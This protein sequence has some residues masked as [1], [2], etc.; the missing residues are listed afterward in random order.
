MLQ[1]YLFN[2]AVK[3]NVVVYLET[4][5]GK[6][7]IAVMLINHKLY[8]TNGKYPEEGKRTVFLAPTRPLV[9]QHL[10]TLTEFIPC[11]I[12]RLTGDHNVDYFTLEEWRNYFQNH[13]ILLCTPQVLVDALIKGFV[14]ISNFNLL[15][16]DEAH[17]CLKKNG[18]HSMHPYRK[19]MDL[20]KEQTKDVKPD[21]KPR[22]L[23][24]SAS[25]LNAL[26]ES[27]SIDK[28]V[29]EIQ[30]IY[31]ATVESYDIR[32]YLKSAKVFIL[33][34]D[35]SMFQ[36]RICAKRRCN[37]EEII[38]V[39]DLCQSL[40][41]EYSLAKSLR[42]AIEKV[43]R[44]C[45][46]E[47]GPWFAIEALCIYKKSCNDS[48]QKL[49][50][51]LFNFLEMKI[52]SSFQEVQLDSE[53]ISEKVSELLKM[54]Y[55]FRNN[56]NC[57]I[58]VNER[59]DANVLF[60]YLKFIS[61]TNPK[62]DFI[63]PGFIC[64]SLS[65]DFI[66]FDSNTNNFKELFEQNKLNILIA[67]AVLE[68]GID[69]P[70]C[71]LVIRYDFTPNFR[72]FVQSKGRARD[73]NSFYILM[74]DSI[75]EQLNWKKLLK[76]YYFIE[77]YLTR[78]S[79]TENKTS[80]TSKF[81][82]NET[83]TIEYEKFCTQYA[84]CSEKDSLQLLNHYLQ[85]LPIDSF[86]D[87]RPNFVEYQPNNDINSVNTTEYIYIFIFPINSSIPG[88]I[89]GN[90][91]PNKHD[92]KLNCAFNVCKYLYG[93][94]EIDEHLNIKTK[95]F[96]ISNHYKELNLQIVIENGKRKNF[97][98]FVSKK[99]EYCRKNSLFAE[100][101][102][103]FKI[104]QQWN[105]CVVDFSENAPNIPLLDNYNY[106]QSTKMGFIINQDQSLHRC[107]SFIYLNKMRIK[108]NIKHIVSFA[109]FDSEKIQAISFFSQHIRQHV[110][111]DGIDNF[112]T[113]TKKTEDAINFYYVP[114]KQTSLVNHEIDYDLIY[115]LQMWEQ[116][117]EH[118]SSKSKKVKIDLENRQN[119]LEQFE[120]KTIFSCIHRGFPKMY[121][122]KNVSDVLPSHTFE[123]NEKKDFAQITTYTDYYQNNYGYQLK[124]LDLPL[125]NSGNLKALVMNKYKFSLSFIIPKIEKEKTSNRLL[126]PIE[127]VL[128]YPMPMWS[129]MLWNSMPFVLYRLES[130]LIGNDVLNL[131]QKSNIRSFRDDINVET[132]ITANNYQNQLYNHE[133]NSDEFNMES[134]SETEDSTETNDQYKLTNIDQI[135]FQD[136]TIKTALTQNVL[137]EK[138]S[139]IISLNDS[140]NKWIE[141]NIKDE[142]T[143]TNEFGELLEKLRNHIFNSKLSY[144]DQRILFSQM[145]ESLKFGDTSLFIFTGDIEPHI[146]SIRFNTFDLNS[147]QYH[148]PNPWY[149]TKALTIN[150]SKDIWD[151]EQLETVGDSFLKMTTTLYLYFHY[152][153]YDE[154]K[155]SLLKTAM[156]CNENLFRSA[157]IKDLQMYMIGNKL[158][159]GNNWIVPFYPFDCKRQQPM[160]GPNRFKSIQIMNGDDIADCVEA[161]I[162][163]FIVYGSARG[164]LDFFQWIGL[165]CFDPI[166][167]QKNIDPVKYYEQEYEKNIETIQNEIGSS[168]M[169][170]LPEINIGKFVNEIYNSCFLKNVEEVINYKF[171]HKFYLGK[172]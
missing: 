118:L 85:R 140:D 74:V 165:K 29:Q 111:M 17:W 146:G 16:F 15:I 104:E 40:S 65:K 120:P 167:H 44:L 98:E 110:L 162:G 70:I 155:L 52:R 20:Y 106:S 96:L 11:N 7:M 152:P 25:I 116:D 125:L 24:L 54:L 136:S 34:T 41:K 150:R 163:A 130:F 127:I 8:Q 5:A 112:P 76:S 45:N 164:A 48:S 23:G 57:I 156:I 77:Q 47:M 37:N 33:E 141:N 64:G 61:E 84:E 78:I 103:Q 147:T 172:L 171:Q 92:A 153:S 114:V 26:I 132:L 69:V 12:A 102:L 71:N 101:L 31:E 159:L 75:N 28:S 13:E 124:Y 42:K 108:F 22:V 79:E 109:L 113:L 56:L 131:V 60:R 32:R 95:E 139:N 68:E 161:L 83:K 143:E 39:I 154:G 138:I 157:L 91:R 14:K 73:P 160:E 30:D 148:Y 21:E 62:Y 144:N 80:L 166:I 115:L 82:E 55:I 137:M 63:K 149:V 93:V 36:F 169:F 35:N 133:N 9:E 6:T 145:T 27:G 142:Q 105:L 38:K 121:Y 3:R 90:A 1:K 81:I 168:S 126:F 128:K 107:E 170:Q 134:E 18:R 122:A 59:I 94:G 10:K 86:T 119:L 53:L 135:D 58:F 100:R 97:Q 50:K 46:E 66:R 49:L 88:F 117:F 158:V 87:W 4:G 99:S 2:I 72:S 89:R 51:E 151:L 67:T 123:L 19:L 43:Q 129:F